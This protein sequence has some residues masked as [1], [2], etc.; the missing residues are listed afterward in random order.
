[1]FAIC[2]FVC[3]CV[4]IVV[5]NVLAVLV[6]INCVGE[7][8]NPTHD[9]QFNV[10]NGTV[11]V[12]GCEG[13]ESCRRSRLRRNSEGCSDTAFAPRPIHIIMVPATVIYYFCVGSRPTVLL[14]SPRLLCIAIAVVD[15]FEV[16]A[17][18]TLYLVGVKRQSFG[19]CNQYTPG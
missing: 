14:A 5:A 6:W 16:L 18:W 3:M 4:A 11:L 13:F 2:R 10:L 8:S 7:W 1:M 19:N 17:L 9:P 15:L 12:Y